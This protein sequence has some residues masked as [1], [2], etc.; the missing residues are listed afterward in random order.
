MQDD[1]QILFAQAEAAVAAALS[2]LGNGG[3]PAAAAA[4]AENAAADAHEAAVAAAAA[5]GS[6]GK[7]EFGRDMGL[8]KRKELERGKA[9]R[10]GLVAAVMQELQLLRQGEIL[11]SPQRHVL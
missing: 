6:A 9:R 8:W 4:A 2:V 5:D 7:D 1:E 11:A 10:D 3:A